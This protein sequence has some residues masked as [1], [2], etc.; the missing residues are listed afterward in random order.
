MPEL[1]H[2]YT[3]IYRT[4]SNREYAELRRHNIWD[5]TRKKIMFRVEDD[6]YAVTLDGGTLSAQRLDDLKTAISIIAK[7]NGA[8]TDYAEAKAFIRAK[9]EK[10][11]RV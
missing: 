2:W 6:A 3:P 5:L 4:T 7:H 8:F 1:C 9:N 10:S 11:S